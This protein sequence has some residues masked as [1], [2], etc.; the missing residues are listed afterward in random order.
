MAA[1]NLQD[2]YAGAMRALAVLG[3]P[4]SKTLTRKKTLDAVTAQ[5]ITIPK[6]SG[7][8]P[9]FIKINYPSA[10][11][12]VYLSYDKDAAVLPVT[13][14]SDGVGEIVEN[15]DVIAPWTQD[16]LSLIAEVGGVVTLTF[17]WV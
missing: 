9:Q 5:S 15:S 7:A 8:K 2:V 3:M 6:N 16:S 12:A 13:D 10:M 1:M 4:R 17:I 14:T 11:G